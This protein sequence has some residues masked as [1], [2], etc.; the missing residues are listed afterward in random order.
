VTTLYDSLADLSLEA[1]GF[2]L[3]TREMDTSGGFTRTTTVVT[4][5]GPGATGRGEDVTYET[6]D[7]EALWDAHDAGALDWGLAGS[8]TLD[9]FSA[10]LDGVDLFPEPPTQ[11]TFRHYRRWAVESAALDL[12]LRQ[13]DTDLATALDRNYDP[14]RFVASTRLDIEKGGSESDDGEEAT[15]SAG[16]VH[17][18]LDID[19]DLEFKL[20]PTS[21]WDRELCAEL[22]ETGAVRVLDFKNYY[23]GTDVDSDPDP[24][25]YRRVAESFPDAVL[26][27]AK[28]TDGTRDALA[29]TGDRLSWDY[30]VTGVESVEALPVDPQWLNVKPSRFG[31]VEALLDTVEYCL[32]RGITMYGGGQYELDVG[33]EHLH[34]VASAFYP[35]SPNDVAPKAYNV[36]E[37]HADVP[38]S[39]LTPPADP[40]GLSWDGH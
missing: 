32:D 18:W 6:D 27:D 34:A 31:T 33:R 1:E 25:L 16:R 36:P 39:P 5:Q 12:A 13:A 8:Y 4:L 11:E 19:P 7:H 14:V 38:S 2:D 22:A 24:A 23:E 40:V 26:E 9:S 30:P 37:P 15:P 10:H 3:E 21:D 28:L 20:D 35:D 17:A 29:G